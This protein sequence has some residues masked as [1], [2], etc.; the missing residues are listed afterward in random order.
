[1]LRPLA[2]VLRLG[3]GLALAAGLIGIPSFGVWGRDAFDAEHVDCPVAQRLPAVADLTVARTEQADELT[4]SWRPP[5]SDSW[6]ALGDLRYRARITAIVESKGYAP[7]MRT[8]PLGADSV[9]FDNLPLTAELAISVALT[10]ETHVL[11]HVADT[12]FVLSDIA[13]AEAVSSMAAPEFCTPFYVAPYATTE[14][15]VLT[16]GTI[17]EV[18]AHAQKT[19]G[20]FYY[21]GFGPAF[22]NYAEA[23]DFFRVGLAHGGPVDLDRIDFSHYRLRLERED[24]GEIAGFRPATVSGASYDAQVLHVHVD[25]DA[26]AL[27]D[28]E[29]PFATLRETARATGKAAVPALYEVRDLFPVAL[30]REPHHAAAVDEPRLGRWSLTA[31]AGPHAV[32]NLIAF[33][34]GPHAYYDFPRD[35]FALEGVYTLT[36]WAEDTDGARISP[37]RSLTMRLGMESS[38]ASESPERFA[39]LDLLEGWTDCGERRS[40]ERGANANGNDDDAGASS[41]SKIGASVPPTPL[42]PCGTGIALSN[43]QKQNPG[44]VRDC[45]LLLVLKDTL[46]PDGA[47][48]RSWSL[49]TPIDGPD[50]WVGVSLGG[51]PERVERLWLERLNLTGSIPPS[52]SGLDQL[53]VLNLSINLQLSGPIPPELGDLTRLRALYA[54]YSQLSGSIPAELGNLAQLEQLWLSSNQLSGP[55][56]PELGNL[57]RLQVLALSLNQLS[58]PIPPELGNLAQLSQLTLSS[59]NQLS[60]PIPAQLGNLTRLT[61]LRMGR[62]QLNGPIPPELGNLTQLTELDLGDNQLS[63]PIPTQLGNL[64]RLTQLYLGDNQLSGAIPTQLGNLTQLSDLRLGDNQL[65]DPIPS[66]LGNLTQLQFLYLDRN[67]LSGAIPSQLGN[68]TRLQY[69]SLELNQLSDPIPPELGNLTQLIEL[70][71]HDNRLSGAIP[72]QLGNLAQLQRLYLND[73]QLSGAIPSQLSSLARLEHLFLGT[74]NTYTGCIPSGLSSIA[75]NDLASLGLADCS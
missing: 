30:Q 21:L 69:L 40:S 57:T 68:L 7:V 38:R 31:A 72:S 53:A 22:R 48:L 49:N 62:N 20:R 65:S 11:S 67:Q 41:P 63:D 27:R 66:Q 33:A 44:L 23:Q 45:D 56:P 24:E 9:T 29:F 17:P 51:T 39:E 12:H 54:W 4:V 75:T 26:A 70:D 50:S 59:N 42:T 58:G 5:T 52:L 47:P 25:W 1:M 32:R 46:D 74:G 37:S 15:G 73:N 61:R 6:E 28:P 16:G 3:A 2:C 19:A 36:A 8:A 71:L 35:L 14:G 55:I 18:V 64:T 34:P 60:G 10:G 43:A 13:A